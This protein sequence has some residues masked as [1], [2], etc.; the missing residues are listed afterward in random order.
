[1]E[2][3]EKGATLIKIKRMRVLNEVARM[4]FNVSNEEVE[5]LDELYNKIKREF[6]RLGE[7]YEQY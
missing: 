5:K 2:T 7:I 1:L 4:K 6:R 3:I